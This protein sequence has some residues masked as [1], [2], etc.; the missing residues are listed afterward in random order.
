[1]K[2]FIIG[3][4]M[5]IGVVGTV[6]ASDLGIDFA[7]TGLT[8]PVLNPENGQSSVSMVFLT[9]DF[10]IHARYFGL[11]G[12]I[13]DTAGFVWASYGTCAISSGDG[14]LY[15]A[16]NAENVTLYFSIDEPYI[17]GTITA[18]DNNGNVFDRGAITIVGTE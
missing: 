18:V 1:M 12:F 7:I 6:E 14:Q 8:V 17:G 13:R 15:C 5:F 2:S 16:F 3:I 4:L 9:A 11:N 10:T